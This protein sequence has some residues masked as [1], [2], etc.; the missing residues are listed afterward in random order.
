MGHKR[1]PSPRALTYPGIHE[2][3]RCGRCR[4][5]PKFCICQRWTPLELGT[6]VITY[7]HQRESPKS[8]NTAYFAA[9]TL[10]NFDVRI[11]G[12]RD[13]VPK[14]D[15]L[16]DDARRVCILFPGDDSEV[17]SQAW[18]DAD[19]R[20]VTLVV[21]DGSWRQARRVARRVLNAESLPRVVLPPGAPSRYIQR[22]QS[23]P[24]HVSTFEAIARALGV[25]EGADVQEALEGLFKAKVENDLAVRGLLSRLPDDWDR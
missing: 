10:S 3:D 17:L 20:P 18:V 2:S 9:A 15:D 19:P 6:R 25:L 11:Y 13:V 8:S 14:S 16:I 22:R 21:P 7:V 12:A 24:G 5:H 23:Q 1:E 4:L